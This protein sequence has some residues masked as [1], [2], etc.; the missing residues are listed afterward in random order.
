MEHIG[1]EIVWKPFF[2]H[3]WIPKFPNYKQFVKK[4][5][6]TKKLKCIKHNLLK[7]KDYADYIQ[8]KFVTL[9]F[10]DPEKFNI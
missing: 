7:K 3:R 4:R 6:W 1:E 10:L 8:P 9:R 2:F 5:V